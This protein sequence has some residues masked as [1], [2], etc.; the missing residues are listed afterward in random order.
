MKDTAY[1]ADYR[2][3]ECETAAAALDDVID[4]NALTAEENDW[5]R[6]LRYYLANPNDGDYTAYPNTPAEWAG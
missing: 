1:G 5:A 3:G 2:T 6:L 4:A